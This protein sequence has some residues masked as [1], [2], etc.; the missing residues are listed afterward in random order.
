M[1]NI[2]YPC[3]H[4]VTRYCGVCETSQYR[5]TDQVGGAIFELDQLYQWIKDGHGYRRDDAPDDICRAIKNR[6]D[7]LKDQAK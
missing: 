2:V 4:Q 6:I 7:Q 5:L 1:S 3:K